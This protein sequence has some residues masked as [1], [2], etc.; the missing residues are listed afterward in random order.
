[1]KKD[2]QT[3]KINTLLLDN[4]QECIILVDKNDTI[5]DFNIAAEKTFDYNR[6]DVIGT[7]LATAIIPKILKNDIPTTPTAPY[8]EHLKQEHPNKTNLELQLQ[9]SDASEFPAEMMIVPINPEDKK[10]QFILFIQDI[11]HRNQASGD[12]DL[13]QDHL[14]T[15]VEELKQT[16]QYMDNIIDSMMDGLFVCDLNGIVQVVNPAAARL[17]DSMDFEIIGMQIG[18]LIVST[19]ENKQHI[20][21]GL[22]EHLEVL[23]YVGEIQVQEMVLITSNNEPLPILLSGAALINDSGEVASLVIVVSDISERKN[24]EN[25]QQYAAFKSGVAEMSAS[26]LHNIGNTIGGISGYVEKIEKDISSLTTI[27]RILTK[28]QKSIQTKITQPDP[29]M[30]KIIQTFEMSATNVNKLKDEHL[31]PTLNRISNSVEHISDIIRVQQS[32]ATSGISSSSFLLTDVINDALTMQEGKIDQYNI[33]IVIEINDV[34]NTLKLPRNPLLQMLM[35]LIKNSIE[36]IFIRNEQD[37]VQG[38]IIINAIP[39]T[40]PED[41]TESW[42][43][44]TVT[45]NGCGIAAEKIDELFQFGKTTKEQGSG[46]GLHTVAN[47]A[48]SIGGKIRAYNDGINQ[49]ASFEFILPQKELQE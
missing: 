41:Q 7:E 32:S 1:M 19:G 47:F 5:I 18:H 11:F 49:G 22:G 3:Q 13:Y 15:V 20:V 34:C 33:K 23:M 31:L 21:D 43:K 40:P 14:E 4:A 30:K 37:P 28:A 27:T 36:A 45:D 2:K 17:H 10:P 39:I 25:Q 12:L 46:I 24:L 29:M 42:L 44:L 6:N 38:K 26:I 48:Q 35:N 16:K 8:L 9:R